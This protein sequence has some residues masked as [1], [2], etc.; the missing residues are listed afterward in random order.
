M[1]ARKRT[2]AL[3]ALLGALCGSAVTAGATMA[4]SDDAVVSVES[5]V[6]EPQTHADYIRKWEA[7]LEKSGKKLPP[8]VEKMTDQE[9][10]EAMWSELRKHIVP[11]EQPAVPAD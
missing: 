2:V 1:D 7:A 5:Q 9:I 6:A 3:A 11:K 10:F 4:L 8:G